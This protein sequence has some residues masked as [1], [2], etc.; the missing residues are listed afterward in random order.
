M[1]KGQK[2]LDYKGRIR[3][4]CGFMLAGIVGGLAA[5]YISHHVPHHVSKGLIIF[6]GGAVAGILTFLIYGVLLIKSRN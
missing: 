1:N 2:P 4:Y 3:L 5:K 6:L